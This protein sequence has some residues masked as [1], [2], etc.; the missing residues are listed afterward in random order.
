MPKK[1]IVLLFSLFIFACEKQGDCFTV[2]EKRMSNGTY[3]L[4]SRS[5]DDLV[6]ENIRVNQVI[7]SEAVYNQFSVG[8]LYC[9]D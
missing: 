9:R 2:R 6:G 7:V 5:G 8:E 3:Y 4:L 1:G